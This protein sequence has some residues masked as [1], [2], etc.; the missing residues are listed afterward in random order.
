M[1]REV[2]VTADR[3][4]EDERDVE[5]L[6]CDGAKVEQVDAEDMGGSV[7]D[8]SVPERLVPVFIAAPSFE[9]ELFRYLAGAATP[10]VACQGPGSLSSGCPVI[11]AM[12]S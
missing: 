10:T 4:T 7:L 11:S 6:E 3:R 9:C 12:S 5:V 2:L 1:V 8:R